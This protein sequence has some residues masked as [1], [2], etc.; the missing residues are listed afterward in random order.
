MR[1]VDVGPVEVVAGRQRRLE[2]EDR[3][4]GLGQH[5][6]VRLDPHRAGRAEGVDP[7]VGVARVDEDLLVL[8]VPGVEGRPLEAHRVVEAVHLGRA[9]HLRRPGRSMS[10]TRSP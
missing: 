10:P 8:L 2:A 9:E 5:H 6:A 4:R 1:E 7:R 3:R